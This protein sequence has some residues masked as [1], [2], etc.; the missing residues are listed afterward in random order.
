MRAILLSALGPPDVLV[1]AEVDDPVARPGQVLID[2]ELASITFVE[3]QV[4]AGRAPNPAMIPQLPAIPGNGVGGLV[5]AVGDGVDPHLVGRRVV[6]TTGGSGGY[7]ERV[8]VP[9]AG[10]IDVPDGVSLRDAVALLADGRTATTLMRAAQVKPGET[11]FVEAAAGGVGSLLVQLAKGAGAQVIAAAGGERKL[12]VARD[13][14][15][16]AVVDYTAAEWARDLRDADVGVDVVFDGVGGSIGRAAF[17][18]LRRGGR[19]VAFGMAGGAFAQ[20]PEDEAAARGVT[21][22]GGLG[23]APAE[24]ADL[25]RAAL[26][27]AEAGR[28][29]PLIGQ[30]FPLDRAA[31]AHRAIESRQTVGKTLLVIA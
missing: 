21:I 11:V 19:H 12:A 3:T 14:G 31:D 24:M 27:Q 4:R 1:L 30:T 22:V 15:A 20:L 26:A 13:L 7:A 23:I 29:R 9:A 10:L 17:G 6:S 8:A 18:L 2:V 16:D 5:S 25:T 28:L